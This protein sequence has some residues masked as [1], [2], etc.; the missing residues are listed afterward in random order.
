MKFV[1]HNGFTYD[2]EIEFGDGVVKI[3]KGKKDVGRVLSPSA[4]ISV[5]LIKPSFG[6]YLWDFSD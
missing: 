2:G 4:I 3:K 5:D 6:A 1:G